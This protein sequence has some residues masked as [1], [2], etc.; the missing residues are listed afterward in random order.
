MSD[1]GLTAARSGGR[2]SASTTRPGWSS[3]PGPCAG[4]GVEIVSTGITAATIEAAGV[5]V[6]RVEELTGF[7]EM[8]RRPGQ[9]AA[10]EGAR[11]PARRPAA[12]PRTPRS[13]PSSASSRSTCWCRN[14]Y[15]F[16][17]TVASGA[18][19]DECVEQIDIGGPAMVR[20]AAKN[21]A[22]RRGGDR[23]RRRTRS[24]L[25]ALADGGFTL[26]Q[27]RALAARAFAD[28]AEYDVAGGRVVRPG[29]GRR[30]TDWWPEFAGLGAAPRGGAA[31]RREPAPGGRALRRP[32]APRRAGPGRAAARQGDVLQQL[33][34]RR[35]RL[36]GR[37]RL[38]PSPAV[39]IIKHANPCGIAV[40]ADVAEAHRKAHAC[41]PVSAFGGVIAVNRAGHRRAG[42]AGRRDL[43]RGG[44]RPVLRGRRGRG[45]APRR[46][47]C[48]CCARPAWQ[49]GRRWSRGRSPAACWCRRADRDRRRRRRPG[50]LAAG[51]RRAGVDER[52]ARP[53]VRLAGGA[54]GEVQRDPAGL[55]R[56]HRR[57]R[58][59]PG[60]PGR[61]G[62][63]GGGPGRRPG[64][65]ARWPPRTRSSRSPTASQ[66]LIDGGRDARSCSPA[67]RSATRRS[68]PRPQAAGM[69]MYLTG[70]RHFFH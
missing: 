60:Q 66:M 4:A 69:T 10:P 7:P 45:A 23:R 15:P 38:R 18:A 67:A 24:V 57:R 37:A 43:H 6:T 52:A 17:E 33:R 16:T 13:S 63:A 62:P 14:L 11:R 48:A 42:R 34:R 32:G 29:A 9:D 54:R 12:R 61:L 28:I 39:A 22:E 36:A 50:Q 46:R 64:R 8:P 56:R 68:S 35:R 47:T 53:G 40:G 59:G 55:G 27:R 58:H 20:A 3:W 5:P 26:A 19:V 30:P 25:A 51:R 49:P 41:D 21:H 70:T 31:L 2:W 65:A 1:V 44:R